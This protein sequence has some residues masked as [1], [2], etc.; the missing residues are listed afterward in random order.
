MKLIKAIL[1]IFSFYTMLVILEII[2]K[3]ISTTNIYII[4]NSFK[5]IYQLLDIPISKIYHYL[6]WFH[7]GI[8]ILILGVA[9][10]IYNFIKKEV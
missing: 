5:L 1:D 8:P 6:E 10:I 4:N 9:N 7:L 2:A 3:Y